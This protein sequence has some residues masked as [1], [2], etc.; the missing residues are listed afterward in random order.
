[1]LI[2]PQGSSWD[3]PGEDCRGSGPLGRPLILMI[4]VGLRFTLL[5]GKGTLRRST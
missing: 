2:T 5:L 1:M 3:F 4:E